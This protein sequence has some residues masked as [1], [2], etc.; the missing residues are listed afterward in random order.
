M[1][2]TPDSTVPP[3]TTWRTLVGVG[4]WGAIATG[5]A[6]ALSGRNIPVFVALMAAIGVGQRVVAGVVEDLS[7]A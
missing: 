7:G 5:G 6:Y 2:H 1:S 3:G 4:A